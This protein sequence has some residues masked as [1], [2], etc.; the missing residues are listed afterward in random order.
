MRCVARG[1]VWKE[2]KM[3]QAMGVWGLVKKGLVISVTLFLCF[4]TTEKIKSVR[5]IPGW[6][7]REK[8]GNRLILFGDKTVSRLESDP[9]F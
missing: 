1:P 8:A 2:G 3:R 9:L 4:F 5:P 7:C 6:R